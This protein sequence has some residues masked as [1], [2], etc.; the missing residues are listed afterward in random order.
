[1]PRTTRQVAIRPFVVVGGITVPRP[2]VSADTVV[3]SPAAHRRPDKCSLAGHRGA[4]TTTRRP[5]IHLSA[6]QRNRQDPRDERQTL[7]VT[8]TRG[9]GRWTSG[10]WSEEH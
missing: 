3:V 9:G 10:R 1:M 2:L 5:D 7:S 4:G 6:A 8:S